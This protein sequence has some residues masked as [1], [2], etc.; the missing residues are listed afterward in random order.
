MLFLKVFDPKFNGIEE[1]GKI[2]QSFLVSYDD[3]SH[4]GKIEEHYELMGWEIRSADEEEDA[5]DFDLLFIED[6]IMGHNSVGGEW[7]I[8]IICYDTVKLVEGEDFPFKNYITPVE[9][10]DM[11]YF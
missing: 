10:F 9:E 11:V 8:D 6:F 1:E 5:I 2:R 3:D 4:E 7:S